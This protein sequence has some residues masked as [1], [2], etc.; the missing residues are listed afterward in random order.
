M[1]IKA[2]LFYTASSKKAWGIEGDKNNRF[3]LVN[4]SVGK[5]TCHKSKRT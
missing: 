2:S 1:T 4:G 3:G 5:S